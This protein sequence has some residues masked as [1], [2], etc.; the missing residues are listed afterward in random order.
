MQPPLSVSAE[1]DCDGK[2][3]TKPEV[4]LA[5]NQKAALHYASAFVRE[6]CGNQEDASVLSKTCY[7]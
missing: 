4:K 3:E 1:G 7:K 6:G 2:L 5:A